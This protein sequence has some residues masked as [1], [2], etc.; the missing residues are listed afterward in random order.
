MRKGLGM[1]ERGGEEETAKLRVHYGLVASND[2]ICL[3][4]SRSY[5]R[6]I[7][8]ISVMYEYYSFITYKYYFI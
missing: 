4:F 5:H 6:Y 2:V 1:V 7:V 8:T 3:F